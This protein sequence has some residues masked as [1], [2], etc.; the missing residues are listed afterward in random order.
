MKI[1]AR[2]IKTG[3]AVTVTMYL[4]KLLH[5]EPA[6]FGAVS[7]VM[8]MQPSIFLTVKTAR[9]QILVHAIGVTAAI[10]LGYMIGGHPV[11]MGLITIFIILLYRR[12]GLHGSISGGVVAAVFI[13]SSSQDEFL[14][15]ALL[16]TGVVFTGL[17]T[18]MIINVALWPPKYG[19]A[20]RAKL[21]EANEQAVRYFRQALY[22]YV[23]LQDAPPSLNEE[24]RDTVRKLNAEVRSLADLCKDE[25]ALFSTVTTQQHEWFATAKRLRDYN[26]SLTRKAER[27]YALLP[28]RYERRQGLGTPEITAAFQN[29][30]DLL[31]QG[32]A[33][34]VRVNQ[35][36]RDALLHGQAVEPEEINERYWVR[37]TETMEQWQPEIN[38]NYYIHAL[39][40]VAVIANEI[41]TASRD[42]KRLLQECFNK[43]LI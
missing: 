7:A 17:I 23:H 34:V 15:H 25:D 41:K 16:R 26:E 33:G 4:C 11:S 18:A 36:L 28:V 24:Q 35:K 14:T 5:F 2:I 6:F 40:E 38:S 32:D 31:A 19:D 10:A 20:F 22:D 21:H 30:L 8:N 43:G 9:D 3:L 12:I 13:L 1:G 42:A 37:L 27:I 29:V 39:I